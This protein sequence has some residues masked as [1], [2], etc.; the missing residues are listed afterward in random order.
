MDENYN[1]MLSDL[2][3]EFKS[4]ATNVIQEI[5]TQLTIA[6]NA[7]LLAEKL[8]SAN[9][10]PFSAGVSPLCQNYVPSSFK[11]KWEGVSSSLVQELTGVYD[12]N[13][14]YGWEHSSIC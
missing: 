1:D 7:I 3:K 4:I 2:E 10:I 13:S 9:G 12:T 11:D 5:E 8:S 6:N 14:D